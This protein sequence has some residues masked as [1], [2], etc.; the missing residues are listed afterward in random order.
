MIIFGTK[1][2]K[3]N[4]NCG[5]LNVKCIKILGGSLKKKATLGNTIIISV[6]KKKT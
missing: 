3:I 4:D 6:K 1:N 2:I 5:I